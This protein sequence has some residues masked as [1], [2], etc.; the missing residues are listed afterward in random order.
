MLFLVALVGI[1]V[2]PQ[3]LIS[4]VMAT[5]DTVMQQKGPLLHQTYWHLDWVGLLE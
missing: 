1:M 4:R 5:V 2:V 3:G